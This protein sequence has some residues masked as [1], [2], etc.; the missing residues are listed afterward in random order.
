VLGAEPAQLTFAVADLAVELVDQAQ[1]GLDR[2]LARLRKSE[3]S[4]QLAAA[5]TEQIGDGAGRAVGEQHRVHALLQARAVTDQV[6][7]PTCP[8]AFGADE[9]VG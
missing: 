1:A 2:A 9:W 5:D 4:E 7:A 3:P 8:L 6:Q